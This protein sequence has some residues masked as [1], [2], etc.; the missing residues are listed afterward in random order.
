MKK[1]NIIFYIPYKKI[2]D[3]MAQFKLV[4]FDMDGTLIKEKGIFVI[5]EKKGFLDDLLNLL[6]NEEIHYYK[7]SIEVAKLLKG[8]KT[9]EFL[10]I[11]RKIKLQNNVEN[12]IK[13]LKKNNIKSAIASDSYKFLVDDLKKRLGIDYAYANELIINN[14]IITGKLII[15]NK[16]L[17]KDVFNG[18]IF[19]INKGC[20]I[21]QLSNELGIKLNETIAV[22]DGRVDISMIEKAGL[23]IAFNAPDEVRKHAKVIT[24][25]LGIILEYI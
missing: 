19:S 8:Y 7:R 12:I 14:N 1:I 24:N 13:V 4:I 18:R 25:D 9:D 21:E 23:G 15:N 3:I 11:F 16:D 6:R 5:A 2:G 20:I 10:E 22:G 17:K